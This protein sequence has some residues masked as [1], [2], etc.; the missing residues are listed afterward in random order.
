MTSVFS[1]ERMSSQDVFASP[2]DGEQVEQNP[3]ALVWISHNENATY[4]VEVQDSAG[5]VVF[6]ETTSQNFVILNKTLDTGHFR[7]NVFS[8]DTERGWHNF[9]ISEDAV[10]F[11]IP[12]A[13]VILSAVRDDHPRHIFNNDDI[14]EILSRQSHD[15]NTLKTTI[16]MA[17]DQGMPPRPNFH[18]DGETWS[19][20][21]REYF[22]RHRDF[23]DRN[24]VACALGHRLLENDDPELAQKARDYARN[25]LLEICDWNP[26]G[27]CSQLG[28]WGDEIGLS[29]ARC[30]PAVYDWLYDDL[31]EEERI[32]VARTVEQYAL[33]CEERLDITNFCA[34]PGNSH[35]GRIPAY[36]GEA[37][38]VLRGSHVSDNTCERWLQKTLDI[39][40]SLFPFFGGRDGGWAEGVF[41][42]SSYTKW[43]LP[44][45]LAVEK[46][47]G[48]RF[49]NRPFY[50]RVSQ[51]FMHCAPPGWESHPF[52]DG[53]WCLSDDPEW[54]GFMA[55]NPFRVYAER[56]GPDLAREFS[57]IESESSSHFQLHL[58][59]IF[60]PKTPAVVPSL[61]GP[62]RQSRVFRDAGIVSIHSDLAALDT[63]IAVLARAS[64]YGVGSHQHA[65]QGSFAIMSGGVCLIGPSGYFGAAYGTRHHQ[66]WTCQTKAHNCI[67]IDGEGQ[68]YAHTTVGKIIFLEDDGQCAKT[69]IDLSNAYP[70]AK[71]Y[72]RE[73][74]FHRPGQIKIIDIIELDNLGVISW[75][76]HSPSPAQPQVGTDD[77]RIERHEKACVISIRAEDNIPVY[78]ATDQF[79]PAVNADIPE[80]YQ[81]DMPLQYHM[82]WTFKSAKH[83]HIFCSINVDKNNN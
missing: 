11:I 14:P 20:A 59:D 74:E 32:Y 45:F 70:R 82:T 62:M 26:A 37:A 5:S 75:L 44:F 2:E 29:H 51:F 81:V 36:L 38:L 46:T 33:Q 10:P 50:Q 25:C 77:L 7:W 6:N 9:T 56:F 73:I 55:Q 21:Y 4:R 18:H 65:D 53:Y 3:P 64:R 83:H 68:P 63:D 22:G 42:A 35:V 67:L 71:T 12:S 40:G 60:T 79:D 30:L 66:D 13:S 39:Y 24:L 31:S 19:L 16:H 57:R 49:L 69:R 47:H 61:T 1:Q 52:C 41:Y 8:D 34:H 76:L 43:Y 15:I 54:P 80:P 17:L 72:I 78:S 48:F 28:G 27:P 58:L 23:C